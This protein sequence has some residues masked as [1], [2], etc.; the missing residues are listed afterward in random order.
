MCIITGGFYPSD[1]TVTIGAYPIN[2]SWN[3]SSV[4]Y[5]TKP[6]WGEL[7]DSQVFNNSTSVGYK[8][9]DVTRAFLFNENTENGFALKQIAATTS[10]NLV[11]FD[12]SDSAD[13]AHRPYFT[14]EYYETDGVKT[15][16]DYHMQDVGRAGT[17][18]YNDF[19]GQ[20]HIEREDI[21]LY[22][23]YEPVTIKSY[24]NSGLGGSILKKYATD[25]YTQYGVG[26]STNY[27]QT[28]EYVGTIENG[29]YLYRDEEGDII[30]FKKGENDTTYIEDADM[31][32]DT[33]GYKLTG[34]KI[35]DST[36]LINIKITD[37]NN[38]TM[39]FDLYG[40]L[41]KIIV[42]I[43]NP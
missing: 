24:Y 4:N 14:I 19:T 8:G 9:F 31:F 11:L 40:N 16:F 42:E 30:Y 33:K 26:W 12:S 25:L 6:T 23:L 41:V 15:Q 17:V 1:D 28:I 34:E 35:A 27:N 13:I 38:R 32:S 7:L 36:S 21:G 22:C 37:S 18:Y 43:E 39:Y 20:V 2:S 10:E 5:I 3:V 29:R